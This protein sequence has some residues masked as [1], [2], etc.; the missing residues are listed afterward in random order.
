[1]EVEVANQGTSSTDRLVIR[2]PFLA[3]RYAD[4]QESQSFAIST[5]RLAGA[6]IHHPFLAGRYADVQESQSFANS[7]EQGLIEDCCGTKF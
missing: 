1:M 6:A 4:A 5:D 7:T 2:H 3:G